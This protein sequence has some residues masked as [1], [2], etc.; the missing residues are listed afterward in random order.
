MKKLDLIK[1]G[2]FKISNTRIPTLKKNTSIVKLSHV[3]ICSSDINRSFNNGAYDFPLV[4]GHEA[5]GYIHKSSINFKE[6]DKVVIFPLKPCFICGSCKNS[7]FQTCNKYSYYGSRENGAYQEYLRV[8]NWNIVKLPKRIDDADAAL[9]E[10]T[11]VMIHVKNKL[12]NLA[13]GPNSLKGMKGAIIG[14]GFLSMVISKILTEIGIHQPDIFDRNSFKIKYASTKNIHMHHSGELLKNIRNEYDW[15]IEASGDPNAFLKSIQ[16]AKPNA[17]LIWM[18]NINNQLS[19]ET[20]IFSQILR[21]ELIISGSWN[22]SF[23]PTGKSDWQETIDMMR[24]GF[25]PSEFITHYVELNEVPGILSRL[26]D[27]KQR[28]KQF[29]S[30]KAM[31]R[32]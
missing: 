13:G 17:K 24:K 27:H 7:K 12:I 32:F 21:K 16:I 6:G 5:M 9:I 1:N 18:S 14:G 15:V 10:P 11:S 30:I 29:N 2:E 19:I 20:E 28:V 26:Y 4:M 23:K 31:I 25:S 8:N 22:S 3:G